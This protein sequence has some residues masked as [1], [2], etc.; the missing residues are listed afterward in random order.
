[1]IL[2][3]IDSELNSTSKSGKLYLSYYCRKSY[4]QLNLDI[5]KIQ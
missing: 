5:K 3:K 1:M 4:K 2:L